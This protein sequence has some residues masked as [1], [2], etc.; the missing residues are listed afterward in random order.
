MIH[1]GMFRVFGGLGVALFCLALAGPAAAAPAPTGDD[2]DQTEEPQTAAA[3]EAPAPKRE[4]PPAQERAQRLTDK[5]KEKLGLSDEQVPK[6][7]EINLRAAKSM[8]ATAGA[9]GGRRGRLR[10]VRSVQQQRD[11]DLKE[12]LTAEQW[13][14]Y[15]AIR[16]EKRSEARSRM[17]ERRS[18]A[19][20]SSPQG[21]AGSEP[22]EGS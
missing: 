22:R 20:A 16:E 4:R 14:Q 19:G 6:V 3:D 8:D 1:D 9:P 18:G 17:R 2:P 7:A 5:L 11:K 13:K 12:V 10:E 15:E 21:D